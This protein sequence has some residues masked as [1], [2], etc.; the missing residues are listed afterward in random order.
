MNIEGEPRRRTVEIDIAG[1]LI[2]WIT[3]LVIGLLAVLVFEPVFSNIAGVKALMGDIS[4]WILYLPGSVILPLIVSIW[5]GER[6]GSTKG[7]VK[8]AAKAG[9]INALYTTLI[10][11]VAI[12]IIY[13]LIYYISPGSLQSISLVNYAEY[14]IA[15]P[16][17]IILVLTP[18]VSALSGARHS[19]A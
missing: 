13:M 7:N 5:I 3:M 9:E 4:Q 15:I 2:F 8:A 11:I 1:P 18:L 10:Y 14:V 19:G 16:A 17:I 6:V 12:F